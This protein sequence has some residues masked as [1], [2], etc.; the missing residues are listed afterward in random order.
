MNAFRDG[1]VRSASRNPFARLSFLQAVLKARKRSVTNTLFVREAE[2]SVHALL[3]GTVR[4]TYQHRP[5]SGEF[6]LFRPSVSSWASTL[7]P[8]LNF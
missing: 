5:V 8:V 7:K 6:L 1:N 2:P 4:R 3:V